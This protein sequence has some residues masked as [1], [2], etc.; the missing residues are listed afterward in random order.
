MTKHK[1]YKHL[2]FRET[3][4]APTKGRNPISEEMTMNENHFRLT[5]DSADRLVKVEYRIG[6]QLISPRRAGMYDAMYDVASA[7]NIEYS[8][9]LEIRHFFDEEGK[10]AANSMKVYKAVYEYDDAGER[11][12][13]KHFDKDDNPMDNAWGI[14]EYTWK[15]I[16]QEY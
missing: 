11:I 8:G 14:F 7:V 2:I 4:Y 12:G 5:Y 9:N 16:H 1:Y 10:Q 13:L 15:K 6:E 3:P